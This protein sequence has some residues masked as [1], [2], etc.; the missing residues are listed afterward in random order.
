MGEA[1]ESPDPQVV[2]PGEWREA[3]Q[4]AA[5]AGAG[6]LDVFVCTDSGES[7]VVTVRLVGVGDRQ[8]SWIQTSVPYGEPLDSLA[9]VLPAAAWDEREAHELLGLRLAG[10]PDLRP[11]LLPEGFDGHP[12]RKAFPLAERVQTPWPGSYEPSGGRP[13]RPVLPPGVP[14]EWRSGQGGT[15]G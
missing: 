7:L 3:A 9:P 4:A 6:T 13:R 5:D 2:D 1:V 15:D 12:L 8:P 10:H 14:D 11:L